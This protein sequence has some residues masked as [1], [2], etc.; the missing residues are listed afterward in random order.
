MII[1]L[2]T[3]FGRSIYVGMMKGV[4]LAI[5]PRATL[6]DLCHEVNPQDIR[7]AAF[8]LYTSYKF[9]PPGTVHVAVVD[10][11]V[12]TSRNA[13]VVAAGEAYFV[14]PDNGV[15]GFVLEEER[16]RAYRLNNPRYWRSEVSAT[17]HGR[18]I[19]APVAAHLSLGVPPEEMGEPVS[20]LV[21]LPF[22]RPKREE[23]AILGEVLFVD[24]FGNLI[25]NIKGS[26]LPPGRPTVEIKGHRVKGLSSSYAEAEGLLAIVNSLGYLEVA[27]KNGSAA[28]MLDAGPGCEVRVLPEC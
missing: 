5:N 2:L 11:G 14:A 19:F 24:R 26:Q 9:F 21:S 15:L 10:P 1:T 7:Q 18:D 3:D 27:F 6:V 22:P 16:Y 4:I 25:T 23:G 8:L 12:G 13:L 17:F 20:E 28:G